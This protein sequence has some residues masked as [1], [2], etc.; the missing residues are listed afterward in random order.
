VRRRALWRLLAAAVL[1]TVIGCGPQPGV[2][3]T[4]E[5]APSEREHP[6]GLFAQV[7]SH[8]A[9]VN[10]KTVGDGLIAGYNIYISPDPVVG[11]YPDT[12][13][14]YHIQ[15]FNSTPYPGDTNPDDSVVTFVADNLSD[16]VKYYVS[17]RVV[18]SDGT[19]SMP[20]NEVAIVCGPRGECLLPVRYS[21]KNDGYSFESAGYVSADSPA[22]DLYF[23]TVDGGD[24]LASPNRLDGF[25]K[26]NKFKVVSLPD[27][28]RQDIG[29]SRVFEIPPSADKAQI[30]VGDWVWIRMPDRTNALVHVTSLTGEG[31]GRAVKL[32]Y[33]YCPLAGSLIF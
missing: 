4:P 26:V 20:S 5:V 19:L 21:S 29:S 9:T 32:F 25:L 6:V 30:R 17:V 28:L 24:Y 8:R 12:M 10:W 27:G 22:N 2:K 3:Q 16:G 1:A 31:N 15:P 13:L 14:P 7:E 33:A 23:Y 18:Y 11:R